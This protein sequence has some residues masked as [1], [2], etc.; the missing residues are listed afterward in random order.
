MVDILTR[1]KRSWNMSQIRSRDTKPE[2]FVRKLLH[3]MGYR[4]RL[5]SR[6]LPG[7]PDII[8]PRYNSV[9]FVHGCFWHRHRGCRFAYTPKS[10]IEFWKNKFKANVQ[11]D[12]TVA[13][14]LADQGWR[15]LVIWECEVNDIDKLSERLERFLEDGHVAN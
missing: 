6:K 1:E 7:K 5:H 3:R 4:F 10:R 15:R 2:I 9:V 8:L 11:R 12:K 13:R 14:E